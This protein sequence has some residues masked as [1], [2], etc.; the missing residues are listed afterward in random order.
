[1]KTIQIILVL[2]LLS[3]TTN[4]QAQFFKKLVKKAEEKIEREAERRAQRR[5][6]KKIDKTY[7]K[8][9]EEID[10]PLEKKSKDK[11]STQKF[12]FTHVYAMQMTDHKGNNIDF[13]YYLKNNS[14][15]IGVHLPNMQNNMISI[16]DLKNGK[17]IT[18]MEIDGNKTQ[19]TLNFNFKESIAEANENISISK[20]GNTKK[21]LGYTCHEYKVTDEDFNSLVWI[22]KEAGISFPKDFQG[23]GG[24]KMKNQNNNWMF[25][26]EGMVLEMTIT[27]TSRRKP[28]VSTMTCT[29]LAKEK[30]S[31]DTSLYKKMF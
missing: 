6:D 30:T 4:T 11:S 23:S 5:V 13:E 29:K 31:I 18:L 14:N 8:I 12:A 9:E 20:T 25:A 7:D 16:L 15:Y 21:I 1:M 22:T 10:K 24:K 19:M 26:M 3:L 2:L 28:R 27:D 17:N